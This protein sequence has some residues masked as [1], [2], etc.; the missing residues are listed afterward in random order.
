MNYNGY[1]MKILHV[2]LNGPFTENWSYQ[3]NHLSEEHKKMGH[4]VTVIT[5]CYTYN[6]M[7]AIIEIEPVDK[8]L[9]D[10]VRLI[11]VKR[12]AT[13]F[14]K[15]DDVFRPYKIFDL[16]NSLKPDYI[17]NHGLI[18]SIAAFDVVKY[19]KKNRQNTTL[20]ADIH[21][22]RF[23]GQKSNTIKL[24][25]LQLVRILQNRRL[26]K[27][28]K[29]LLSIN[30]ECT[31]YAKAYYKIP[32]E[33]IEFLPIGS[34]YRLIRE[35]EKSHAGDKLRQEN[36]ISLNEVVICHGGKL[37]TKKR[38]LELIDAITQLHLEFPY[39]RLMIFGPI[40]TDIQNV[41]YAKIDGK[42][43]IKYLGQLSKN[44]FYQLFLASD[45][46]VFPGTDS[47]LWLQ[48]VSC[49]NALVITRDHYAE[50]LD[51]G[52]NVEILKSY[53]SIDIVNCMRDLLITNKYKKMKKIAKENSEDVLSYEQIAKR[54]IM[55]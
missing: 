34:D 43:Y 39:L 15:Y 51:F 44:Q 38:T 55:Y 7:G 3:E 26:M 6:S 37:D 36:G 47:A 45:I 35:L 9:N 18:G 20:V 27:Y 32:N 23:V 40:L 54:A 12:H 41:F 16:I 8:I 30:P 11:R 29:V 25:V 52:G 31:N 21:E 1:C 46:A 4:E 22:D 13:L 33:K 24:K 49:G 28:A 48:S 2:H 17:I 19:V 5:N 10:G 53:E 50:Y 42:S 14:K